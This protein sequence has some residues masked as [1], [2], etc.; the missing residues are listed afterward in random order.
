MLTDHAVTTSQHIYV[1]KSEASPL[2]LFGSTMSN[3]KVIQGPERQSHR[4]HLGI[5]L[6]R[7][8]GMRQKTDQR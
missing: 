6:D 2:S 5:R 3:H 7:R 1:I 8:Y 4:L